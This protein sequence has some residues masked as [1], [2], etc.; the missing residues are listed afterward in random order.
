M[1]AAKPKKAFLA[2]TPK[3]VLMDLDDLYKRRWPKNA[4]KHDF[5]FLGEAFEENGM[6]EF[7]TLDE[8]TG[9]V[10]AGNGRVEKLYAMKAAGEAAPERIVV[11]G[12][13]WFVPTVRGMTLRK[14][15]KH[16]FASNKGVE[17]GGWD[18][19]LTKEA[20]KEF[21]GDLKGTG[22][23]EADFVSFMRGDADPGAPDL[24]ATY[25]IIVECKG[26]RQ[27]TTLLRKFQGMGLAVKAIVT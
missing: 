21:E 7:P 20:I 13:K 8:G 22:F 19:T 2:G 26:E 1:S 10:V 3:F 4:K 25:S 5:D 16:V 27:Q 23:D 12:K 15:G 17:L 14:P 24:R 6:A 11:R 18:P 9:K